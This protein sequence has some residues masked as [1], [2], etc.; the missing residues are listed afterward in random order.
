ML[1]RCLQL[2]ALIA[3]VL[4]VPVLAQSDRA[5][6]TGTVKDS[7]GAVLPGVEVHVTNVGTNATQIV[8]TD[9]T[10]SYRVGSLPIGHY[11]V[12]FSKPGFKNLDRTGI[13]LLISQVAEIDATLQVGGAMETVEVTSAA[14]I[15]ETQD[16]AIGANLNSQ[17]V[18]EL[19]LNVQG[20][21]NLSNFIFAYVP[22]AEGTD[23][24]SHIDGSMAMTKE[25]LIDGTSAVSQLGGYISESQPPMEAVQEFE[26]DT[27]GIS[28]DA[29][30]SGG[31]VFRYEMKSGTNQMHGS[32][33]GFMH[34]TGLDA[35]SAANHLA[36]ITD[37]A[38]APAYLRKSDSLSDWGGGVGG[39]VL[40]N[41]LFYYAALERYMQA[42]WALG[43]NSRTVPTD[44]MMGLDSSG[45][46]TPYADLS[47]MLSPGVPVLTYGGAPAYDDCGNPIYRGAIVNPA[48]ATGGKFGCVFVN[49]QIPTN[50]ISK[51]SAQI[52]QLFHKYYQ[53]QTSLIPNQAG[54][55]YNPDPWFHNTQSSVKV[56]YN[57]SNNQHIAGSY[58]YD[59]YPRINADQ[60]G[61]WSPTAQYGGP[62][63]NAYWHN[64]TAAGARLSDTY[65]FSPNLVNTVYA[66]FNRFRNP[67]IAISQANSWDRTLGINNGAGNFPLVVFSSG[68]FTNGGNYQNGWNFSGLG[69]QFNDVY[70]GN[71]YIYSDQ[72]T[73]NRGR[74]NLKLGVE[75][76]AMQFNSHP[77][78]GTFNNITFDPTS[79]A[80]AWYDFNAY[81][82]IGNAF[83]SFLLGDV[84]LATEMPNDPQYGR[85]KAFS[86]YAMDDFK[87]NS[88]LTMNMSLRW[89]FN[90]PYKEKY[91]HWSSFEINDKNTV[92]GEMGQYEY[93]TSGSQSFERRQD[94]Y[95]YAPHVGA[96]YMVT[97]KTVLRG[98]FDIFFTPLNMNTWGGIP[99]QQT[100]NPGYYQHSSESNFNWDSGYQPVLSQVKTPDYTQWGVVSIDPRSL[101]PGNTQQYSVG[102]QRELDA[103]TRFDVDWIQS[104]SYHLQ[105]GTLLT[106]QPTVANMQN[107]VL[108]GKFPDS[109]VA[110]PYWGYGGPGW[111]GITPYPQVAV[112]Y[113]PLFSVGSP[114]GNSDYKSLQFSVTRR[115]VHGL[116]LQGS[117]AWARVHGDVDTAFE[118]L[119]STGS[120][121]NIYDLKNE[122]KNISDFDITHIVKGYYIYNLPFGRGHA[123]L[124]NAG[125]VVNNVV[126]GW[127]LN[128]DFHYN[129]GTPVQVHSTNSYPGFNS[130]YVNLA[131]NCKLTSGSR[132]LYKSWLNTSCFQNPAPGQ[133][134]TAGNFLSQVR[135][136][137]L[138]T[139]DIGLHKSVSMG[140]EG[141]YNLTMRF[142]FFNMFNRNQLAGPDTNMADPNFGKIL[143]YGGLGGRVGQ[144]GARFTY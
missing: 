29:G 87:V 143:N 118:E 122:A 139:E 46:A 55:A 51:T 57:L 74:H 25:V 126:N 131:P 79:T 90:N 124:G 19:P 85:R 112:S 34:S 130:V 127:S 23:Y 38:N 119:W 49:N 84:Y 54:P 3:L 141:R 44:A 27:A 95:N 138:A 91:G 116:A 73:W 99:Y 8:K 96:A 18:S 137:G 76:R 81:N 106:N 32:L 17:A 40:K 108:N 6:I 104:H 129:T 142:E 102:V 61:V 128:G 93:L 136:P 133:L 4:A 114:L 135:N 13:T 41:K 15:L 1:K 71:T 66:T 5:T 101:T 14:P 31:G 72:V 11:V 100:G 77:D 24:S 22:G 50:L 59:N 35:L 67:S 125:P 123:L 60:G 88:R 64:T 16:T 144:F 53:P 68:M 42:M 105:S 121:Q 62:M 33:F 12:N 39:P 94:W 111:Q 45:N 110:N 30:R 70:A 120:L 48:T 75:F 63:A 21:R 7:S 117:Y 56:D 37:P 10:G 52:L 58:Y 69:S 89:D 20:S 92:T 2:V 134:G 115:S 103:S 97:P 83:A 28:A 140:P 132:T 78:Q 36:A 98:N 9:D 47:P 107:Y 26:A 65:I 43:P 109:Y 86:W 113:G 82:M 80:S